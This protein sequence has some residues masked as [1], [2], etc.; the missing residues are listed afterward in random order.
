MAKKI[1]VAPESTTAWVTLPGNTGDFMIDAT[2]LED[3]IFGADYKSEQPD[4]IGWK[5]SSNAIYKGFSGYQAKIL[6]TGAPI[7]MIAEPTT[8]ISGKTYEITSATKRIISANNNVVVLDAAVDHTADVLNIDYVFGHVTFKTAYT[9]VGP[10]TIT[11]SYLPTT[12][13]CAMNKFSLSQQADTTDETDL[14]I[15]QTNNGYRQHGTALKSVSL[16]LNGFY[17]VTSGFLTSLTARELVVIELDPSGTGNSKCRGFFKPKSDKL[18]GKVGALEDESV[19]YALYVP[20]LSSGLLKAPFSWRHTGESTL[21]T[22][23]RTLLDAYQ[24]NTKVEMRYLE[25]GLT[26]KQGTAIWR[27]RGS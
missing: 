20:D 25:D 11:G 4:I 22:G 27:S 5:V 16:D 18:S 26:G 8:L 2:M 10:V 21:N 13:I 3:T 24:N 19:S 15:A 6:K 17:R 7:A 9:V 23:I 14:C 12:Q 1:Q